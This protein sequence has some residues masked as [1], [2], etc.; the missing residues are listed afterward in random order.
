MSILCNINIGYG[1][2]S[3]QMVICISVEIDI[4]IDKFINGMDFVEQF[5]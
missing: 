2:N 1:S 4:L 5:V 3:K